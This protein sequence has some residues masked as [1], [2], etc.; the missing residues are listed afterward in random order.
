M[1]ET[2]LACTSVHVSADAS[3]SAGVGALAQYRI[4]RI[5]TQKSHREHKT[6]ET[7]RARHLVD[8]FVFWSIK[9]QRRAHRTVQKMRARIESRNRKTQAVKRAS[10]RM[11]AQALTCLLPLLSCPCRLRP[12]QLQKMR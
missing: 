9:T 6:K 4:V 3:V 2:V 8:A 5:R 12:M 10:A 7:T 11:G 1:R